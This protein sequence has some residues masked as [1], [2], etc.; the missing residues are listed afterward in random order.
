MQG[1]ELG[2]EVADVKAPFVVGQLGV[3]P[4]DA[5]V[6]GDSDPG[7]AAPP[8]K[9]AG[10]LSEAEVVQGFR[11]V[12]VFGEQRELDVGRLHFDWAVVCVVFGVPHNDIL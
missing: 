5:D 8:D 7:R 10:L 3:L 12:A 6:V 4:R 9:G 11:F 1:A 2:L